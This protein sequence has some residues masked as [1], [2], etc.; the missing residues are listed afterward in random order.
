MA[1]RIGFRDA[2]DALHSRPK[3]AQNRNPVIG[4]AADWPVAAERRWDWRSD[5]SEDA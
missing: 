3:A 4:A 1:D 5:I 2:R